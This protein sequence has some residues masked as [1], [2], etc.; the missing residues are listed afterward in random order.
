M[1]TLTFLSPCPL[2]LKKIAQVDQCTLAKAEG[3]DYC[4]NSSRKTSTEDVC[5]ECMEMADG[6]EEMKWMIEQVGGKTVRG[7][8]AER[9]RRRKWVVRVLRVLRGW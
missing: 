1:C 4:T 2:C 9:G 3:R 7:M 6:V 8:V 5:D